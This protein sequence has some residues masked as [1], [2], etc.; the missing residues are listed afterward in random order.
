MTSTYTAAG[1]LLERKFEPHGIRSD[2]LNERKQV[3]VRLF[4]IIKRAIFSKVVVG[5]LKAFEWYATI[6]FDQF[7]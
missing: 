5:Q 6:Q 4:R 3:E 7:R 2:L 1:T